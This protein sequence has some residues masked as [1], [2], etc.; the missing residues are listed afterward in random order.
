MAVVLLDSSAVIAL[1]NSADA[2]HKK[3]VI[4]LSGLSNAPEI[5]AITLSEVLVHENKA[6]PEKARLAAA[7]LAGAFS[8][9]HS[10]NVAIAIK[11]SEIRAAKDLG[12]ADSI[13]GATAALEGAEL[14]TCDKALAKAHRGARYLG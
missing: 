4:A 12:L 1:A 10:V 3:V 13:I 6:N 2:H 11:A 9:I 5:S 8:K 7:R 14:W